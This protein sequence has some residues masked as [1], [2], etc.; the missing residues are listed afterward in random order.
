VFPADCFAIAHCRCGNQRRTPVLIQAICI[1]TVLKQH[2]CHC[3]NPY[4]GCRQGCQA[5]RAFDVNTGSGGNQSASRFQAPIHG[6]P[7]QRCNAPIVGEVWIRFSRQQCFNHFRMAFNRSREQWRH[8]ATG[9]LL[10]AGP[11]R[12]QETHCAGAALGRRHDEDCSAIL[13][14]RLE[15]S[16]PRP[17][18]AAACPSARPLPR[19]ELA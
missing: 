18:I 10:M 5:R 8:A 15:I 3:G 11:S 7:D 4:D 14:P 13:V 12:E 9:T 16:A 2:P 17:V 1:R 19:R 6:R